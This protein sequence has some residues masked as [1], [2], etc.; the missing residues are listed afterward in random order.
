MT[1]YITKHYP[2]FLYFVMVEIKLFANFKFVKNCYLWKLISKLIQ[3][4]A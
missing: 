4:Y 2:I 1:T 3:I